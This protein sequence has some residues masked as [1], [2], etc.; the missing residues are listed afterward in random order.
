MNSSGTWDV[1]RTVIQEMQLTLQEVVDDLI[2]E[3]KIPLAGLPPDQIVPVATYPW[4]C[5][6]SDL[7]RFRYRTHHDAS[8]L[9]RYHV[10]VGSYT[11]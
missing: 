4:S 11:A 2:S 10:A 7:F 5:S 9:V 1:I 6:P 8:W 3:C